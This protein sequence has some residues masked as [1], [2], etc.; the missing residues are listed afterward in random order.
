MATE[1]LGTQSTG[2]NSWEHDISIS[3]S[4]LFPII[5]TEFPN[6]GKNKIKLLTFLQSLPLSPQPF[7]KQKKFTFVSKMKI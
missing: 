4:T 3:F 7:L 5:L 6:S 2:V 1:R